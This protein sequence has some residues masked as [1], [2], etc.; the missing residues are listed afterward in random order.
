MQPTNP[1]S[2]VTPAVSFPR[3]CWVE[4][5]PPSFPAHLVSSRYSLRWK[6]KICSGNV[7]E[8]SLEGAVSGKFTQGRQW[9][10]AKWKPWPF[11]FQ[12]LWYQLKCVPEGLGMV[13]I[14]AWTSTFSSGRKGSLFWIQWPLFL[15]Q[16]SL[17]VIGILGLMGHGGPVW[18]SFTYW[19]VHWQLVLPHQILVLSGVYLVMFL[20]KWPRRPLRMAVLGRGSEG[21]KLV[22]RTCWRNWHV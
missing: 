8:W 21:A 7:S 16:S 9:L 6:I 10:N 15:S 18:V 22:L 5:R 20:V 12:R 1:G 4:H 13:L 14:T 19:D 2:S 3:D 17:L 11:S